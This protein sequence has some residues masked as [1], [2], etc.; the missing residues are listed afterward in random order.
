MIFAFRDSKSPHCYAGFFL[1]YEKH[2]WHTRFSTSQK[3]KGRLMRIT[4]RGWVL[5][6]LCLF[7]VVT[8]FH[9]ENKR[10]GA[11]N[12]C[13]SGE[14]LAVSD[15]SSQQE[16]EDQVKYAAQIAHAKRADGCKSISGFGFEHIV[17]LHCLKRD[18]GILPQE[19]A[20]VGKG[21]TKREAIANAHEAADTDEYFA[22]GICSLV[23]DFKADDKKQPEW[24]HL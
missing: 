4:V 9:T 16:A 21:A 8:L 24:R 10:Y 13:P 15:A 7:G 1:A 5:I 14:G 22:D 2:S 23:I 17:G 12:M 19:A 18:G 6:A 11:L 20:F 3:R